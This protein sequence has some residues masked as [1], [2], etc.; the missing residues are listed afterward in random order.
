MRQSKTYVL[1]IIMTILSLSI[2]VLGGTGSIRIDP[3]LPEMSTSPADFEIWVQSG[4]ADDPHIFLVITEA[5]Y[6][7]LTG[8]TTVSWSS[9]GG[10]SLTINTPAGW[11]G[12]ELNNSV[13][14]PPG[15]T[16]GAGIPVASLKDHLD[17]DGPIYWANGSILGGAQLTSENKTIT[18]TLSSDDPEMLVYIVGKSPGSDIFDMI[19]PPTIPGF[20][21]PEIPFGTIMVLASMIAALAIY[22]KK[23]SLA[24]LK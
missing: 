14:L 8:D 2:P 6:N 17:T 4:V 3:P 11:T 16:P 18:V 21:I 10:G 1:L 15:L 12:P 22:A 20:V 24:I 9:G 7:G 23:P 5:C 19:V 13:K